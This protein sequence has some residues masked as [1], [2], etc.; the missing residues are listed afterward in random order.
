MAPSFFELFKQLSELE[1]HYTL[2]L[3]RVE[4][5]LAINCVC[6]KQGTERLNTSN[7]ATQYA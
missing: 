4:E 3:P 2:S 6:K 7:R 1:Q 5:I